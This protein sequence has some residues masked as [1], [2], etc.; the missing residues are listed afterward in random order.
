VL[1]IKVYNFNVNGEESLIYLV[2][3]YG[4]INISTG[5]ERRLPGQMASCN[6]NLNS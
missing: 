5:L 4:H 2:N 3:Q 1:S 6:W